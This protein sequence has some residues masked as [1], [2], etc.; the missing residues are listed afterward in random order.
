MKTKELIV[1]FKAAKELISDPKVWIQN[2]AGLDKNNN[3]LSL[4]ECA[5]G[6]GVCFCSLGALAAVTGERASYATNCLQ[7]FA[8]ANQDND[9]AHIND[10]CTHEEVLAFW[11]KAIAALEEKETNNE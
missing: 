8:Y 11:D 3:M 10:Y 9:L 4:Q 7:N 2:A 1:T 6:K 5:E